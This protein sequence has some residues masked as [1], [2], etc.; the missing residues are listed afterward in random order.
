MKRF[1][2]LPS[3][4]SFLANRFS[5]RLAF[6]FQRRLDR[7]QSSLFSISRCWSWITCEGCGYRVVIL[8]DFFI[9][10]SG[11]CNDISNGWR[12]LKIIDQKL[13]ISIVML[14]SVFLIDRLCIGCFCLFLKFLSTKSPLVGLD[15][16]GF[17][18]L[19][20]NLDFHEIKAS[21]VQGRSFPG[22]YF[23]GRSSYNLYFV[24]PW[25]V[26]ICNLLSI[27]VT[28]NDVKALSAETFSPRKFNSSSLKI[29]HPT[30]KGSSSNHHF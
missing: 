27:P 10:A 29:Y 3:S 4:R 7:I 28:V 23:L 14:D 24:S 9:N 25:S 21:H 20:R 30:R 17:S 12:S 22:R 13:D 19:L 6:R 15:D 8:E 11:M 26:W 18:S 16:D 1:H 2:S 5:I